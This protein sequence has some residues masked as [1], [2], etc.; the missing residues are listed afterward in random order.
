L[1]LRLLRLLLRLLLRRLRLLLLLLTLL[2]LL[3]LLLTLL[4]RLHLLQSKSLFSLPG[5]GSPSPVFFFSRPFSFFF[6]CFQ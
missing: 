5:W 3:L 2:L 4:L 1:L 6:P